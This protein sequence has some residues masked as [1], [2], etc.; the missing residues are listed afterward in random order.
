MKLLRIIVALAGLALVLGAVNL[1]IAEKE[2]TLANGR[3]VLLELRPLDPRSLIQGDYM[4]LRYAEAVH[5]DVATKQ[6]MPLRGTVILKLD[7]K[8]VA[9]FARVDDGTA[10]APGELRLKY[11]FKIQRAGLRYGAESFFFQEGDADLYASARY[12]VLRVDAD[13]ASV[14]VGLAGEDGKLIVKPPA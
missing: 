2:E 10:L 12:G 6:E 9:T 5:P 11:K 3:Q 7:E 4:I 13:G 8:G 1:S 14:L